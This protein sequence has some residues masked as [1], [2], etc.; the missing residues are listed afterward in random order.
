MAIATGGVVPDG[1]DA[2]IPFEYVV[3]SDN[4]VE[5]SDAVDTG[6]YV[7]PRGGDIRAGD[8]VVEAGTRLGPAQLGALAAAG[9]RRSC[10]PRGRGPPS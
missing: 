5:I 9:V 7:R 4:S 6:A 10:A 2:V 3:E 1:A 8:L